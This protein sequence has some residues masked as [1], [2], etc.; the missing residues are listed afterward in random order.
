MS[1]QISKETQQILDDI[2]AEEKED[3]F[4]ELQFKELEHREKQRQEAERKAND[5]FEQK[6]KKYRK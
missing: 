6:L 4:K 3:R 1:E 2:K 5:P